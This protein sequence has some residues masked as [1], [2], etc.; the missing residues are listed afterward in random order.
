MRADPLQ[1]P[2]QGGVGGQDRGVAVGEQQVL[3]VAHGAGQQLLGVHELAQAGA[4]EGVVARQG[5]QIRKT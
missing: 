1:Q 2:Q 4:A 3:L 5:L